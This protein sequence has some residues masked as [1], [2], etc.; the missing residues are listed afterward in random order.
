MHTDP[1]SF[2][3]FE[4]LRRIE[5]VYTDRPRLGRSARVAD[6]PVRLAHTPSLAFAPCA[7]DRVDIDPDR[8]PRIHSLML[9]L[10]GPNGALPLHLTEYTLERERTA[11][12]ATFTAFADVFHHRMLSLFYRAWA[13]AQPTVQMDRPD[14]DAFAHFLGALVGIDSPALAERDALPDRFRR[15]M[16]GR[17]VA[18][19]RN[20]E[21]LVTFLGAFFDVPV[22]LEEFAVAW[23]TLPEEGRLR[24]GRAMAGMGTTA[25]L[26]ASV[27]DAQHR[28]RIRLGPMTF[29]DY[30]RFLPGGDA[31]GEL[32]AAVRF[33]AGDSFDW[34]VRLVLRRNEVPLS[35]MGRS[36]RL[37]MSS[38]M[39]CF[40]DPDEADDLVLQPL[41]HPNCSRKP[42]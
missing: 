31:L 17:L 41:S 32:V 15:Y 18:Q 7:M 38:W 42:S 6:D 34:D 39:G 24:M 33:Y 26:G 23:M 11:R 12:D 1:S 30:R 25:V 21:G 28:F 35:H 3:W 36:G 20:A 37:G 9:G 5:C 10:W 19:A 14:E 40:A 4:A 22:R 8:P 13:D 27:R 16:A 2:D 29:A